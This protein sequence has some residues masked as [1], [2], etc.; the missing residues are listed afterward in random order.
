M[1]FRSKTLMTMAIVAVLVVTGAAQ[2]TKSAGVLLEAAQQKE[3]LEG[4]LRG[5]V[6]IYKDVVTRFGKSDRPAAATALLRMAECYE[7]LGDPEATGAYQQILTNYADQ[8]TAASVARS[9]LSSGMPKPICEHCGDIYGSVSPDGKF[10]ATVTPFFG[11]EN[12]GDI[13]LLE[14]AT[15]KLTPLHIEGAGP[16]GA[17]VAVS[18]RL[19]PDMRQ[20]AYQW[21]NASKKLAELRIVSRDAP[22]KARVLVSNP[23]ITYIEPHAW[24]KDGSLLV[25]LERPD[26]TWEIA[27]VSTTTGAMTKVRSLDWRISGPLHETSLSP[28]GRFIAYAAFT[29]NPKAPIPSRRSGDL[30]RQIYVV[31]T[32]GSGEVAVTSGAGAKRHPVWTPDGRYVTYVSNLSG[33]WGL[34][35]RSIV[36]GKPSGQAVLVKNNIGSFVAP[37]GITSG[38]AYHYYEGR[39]GVV[40]TT[41]VGI[42]PQSPS[43]RAEETFV[44]AGP[45]WSPDGKSIAVGRPG[46]SGN[47]EI[48]VRRL[49]TGDERTL[50]SP[51]VV[52]FPFTWFADS[53]SLLVVA[54]E[55]SRRSWYRVNVDTGGVE[56]LSP[57]GAEGF[58]INANVRALSR[59]G[60]TLYLGTWT[61]AT[62]RVLNRITALD[63]TTGTHR[64]VFRIPV[65]A[66][67]LPRAA[68]DA[69]LATSPDGRHLAIMFRDRKLGRTRLATVQVDGQGYREIAEPFNAN[70]IRTKLAWS[71]DGRWIYFTT[72]SP[73][74]GV[75]SADTD[76]HRI[77][78]VPAGG[79]AIELTDVIVEG[80]ERF[81]ISPDGVRLAYSRLQ[82]EGAAELLWSL[83]VSWLMKSAR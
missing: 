70:N 40:R 52:S 18:P 39:S 61:S 74:K 20:V 23:E 45:S 24:S 5:A 26:E 63:L 15:N 43:G 41:I 9:R 34:W 48:V 7:K 1:T 50:K 51:A 2:N 33:A 44:G 56:K 80:L 49:D 55:D 65:D 73:T 76:V 31:A 11:G 27:M 37:L 21:F 3:T 30:E 54:V 82:P 14:L 35:A 64:D 57:V 67:G 81:D 42:G 77:A 13:G 17:G 22:G 6:A 28:D 62:D 53:R 78:R 75:G 69:A 8:A 79:G 25:V 59:D 12:N 36:S 46:I 71:T 47:E 19:S 72:V 58:S 68:Q 32:D 4:D 66:D 29:T 83:D 60:R 16:Q 10:M 38:G